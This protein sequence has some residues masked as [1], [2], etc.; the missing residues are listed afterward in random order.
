MLKV[1]DL[2]IPAKPNVCSGGK[3]TA[4]RDDPEHHRSEGC[5][6]AARMLVWGKGQAVPCP[7]SAPRDPGSAKPEPEKDLN[8]LVA[9]SSGPGTG[10][11]TATP[12]QWIKSGVG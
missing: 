6:V 11:V 3:R 7:A 8:L 4:F 2:R 10:S 1:R 5:M 12:L 9:D